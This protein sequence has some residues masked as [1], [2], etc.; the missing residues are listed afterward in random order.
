MS[1]SCKIY[2][3]LDCERREIRLISIVPV[4]WGDQI[5]CSFT[6][7][8]LDHPNYYALSYVWGNRSPTRLVIVDGVEHQVIVS[9]ASAL[10]RLRGFSAPGAMVW[11]DALCM[12]QLDLE[13]RSHQVSM[14]GDIYR[15][16]QEALIWIGEEDQEDCNF[17][18]GCEKLQVRQ[19]DLVKPV[20]RS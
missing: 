3:P 7:V 6:I 4:D 15:L 19:I 18:I 20:S 17:L 8:S 5:N 10:R 2:T 13:E 14:M 12:N 16:T 9:L 11:A 1:R